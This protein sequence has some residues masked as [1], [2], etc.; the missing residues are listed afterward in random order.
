[1][2]FLWYLVILMIIFSFDVSGQAPLVRELRA[3]SK[4][5]SVTVCRQRHSQNYEYTMAMT[6][7]VENLSD[8]PLLVSKEIRV[9]TSIAIFS[10]EENAK[11]GTHLVT[12]KQ[13]YQAEEGHSKEAILDDFI[14]VRKGEKVVVKFAPL[15]LDASTQPRKASDMVLQ[16]GKYWLELHFSLLPEYFTLNPSTIEHF[17]EKWNDIGKLDDQIIA[18]ESFPIDISL[19]PKSPFCDSH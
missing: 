3:S 11:R 2:K 8:R 1:M 14:V 18:T 7:L 17:R 15:T 5:V 4:T 9:I 6:F 10:S 12:I 13:E 16:R 19:N